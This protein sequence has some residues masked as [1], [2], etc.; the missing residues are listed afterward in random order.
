MPLER[1]SKEISKELMAVQMMSGVIL[2]M[3]RS[4]AEKLMALSRDKNKDGAPDF[5]EFEGEYIK[6]SRIE[7]VYM[8][9]TM[10]ALTRRKNGQWQCVEAEW[11]D[12]FEKCAC[13][14]KALRTMLDQL[15]KA[16]EKCKKCEGRGFVTVAGN[17]AAEC[18]CS[19]DIMKAISDFK[20]E[21][22]IT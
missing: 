12:R 13:K 5:I 8:P 6:P 16:R 21:H 14:P 4:K 2:W 10:D 15:R 3:E 19:R 18:V 9:Q 22:D 7:G 11:H 1:M 17:R 20:K